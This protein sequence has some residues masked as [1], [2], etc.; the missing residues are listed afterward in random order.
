[1]TLLVPVTAVPSATDGSVE[2]ARVEVS[3]S[4]SC[5]AIL[6]KVWIKMDCIVVDSDATEPN[7]DKVVRVM[8]AG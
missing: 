8:S 2:G 4:T 7:G 3:L 6:V 1:M 5:W